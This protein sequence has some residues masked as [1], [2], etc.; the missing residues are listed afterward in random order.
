VESVDAIAAR[1][2]LLDPPARLFASDNASGVHPEYL[3]AIANANGGHAL[4][5][6]NDSFTRSSIDAFRNLCGT[7]VEVLFCFGGT[8]SN[9]VALSILLGKGESI[10]CCA[11]AHIAI[12]ETGAPERNLG[13]KLQTV[14]HPDGKLI[15]LDIEM[16]TPQI[17]NVH[18]VQPGVVSISQPTEMGTLYSIDELTAIVDVAHRYNMRVHL[19]GARIANAIS[20][21]GGDTALF[22][23]M[24]FDIGIDAVSFGGTKNAMLNAEAVL[25]SPRLV[26]QRGPYL[27][28][29]HT[30]LPSKMR[31]TS[32]QF[33]HALRSGL[34]LKTAHDANH[35]ARALFEV[36]SD[37]DELQLTSPIVN[38]LYPTLRDPEKSLLQGWSFFWDWDVSVQQVRW[39]ASWDTD[40]HDIQRFST[41]VREVV[42]ALR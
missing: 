14:A 16:V 7:D 36:L 41:G 29:Q 27:H 40:A 12:D 20:A 25:L 31:F 10:L 34:W 28:K 22:R 3:Q 11:S 24:T 35:S 2:A 38:S 30:Q 33:D 21:M 13:V 23:Q 26:G 6:G 19:D 17:G 42:S 37:L 1:L 32:A 4:A 39:M 18:H 5:Y 9:V 8:G 15:P